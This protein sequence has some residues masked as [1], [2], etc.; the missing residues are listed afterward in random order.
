MKIMLMVSRAGKAG[1]RCF[2]APKS[3]KEKSEPTQT[4]GATSD[5]VREPTAGAH[6]QHFRFAA[7]TEN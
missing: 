6:Q 7:S 2:P 5:G 3:K 4:F 1:V